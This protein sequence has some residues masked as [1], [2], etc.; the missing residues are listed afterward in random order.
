MEKKF[1]SQEDYTDDDDCIIT[2]CACACIGSV[3]LMVSRQHNL[4]VAQLRPPGSDLTRN[5]THAA[6][7]LC[8]LLHLA[9]AQQITDERAA[10]L[11]SQLWL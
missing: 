2:V 4:S 7:W 11:R 8:A 9:G 6:A 3:F 1:L 5:I 10:A